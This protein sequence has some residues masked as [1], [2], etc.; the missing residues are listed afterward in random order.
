MVLVLPPLKLR[1]ALQ[2]ISCHWAQ[3]CPNMLSVSLIARCVNYNEERLSAWYVWLL[4]LFFLAMILSCGILFCLQYWLKRRSNFPSRRTLAIFALSDSDS[5]GGYET[6]PY[7]FSG[8]HAHSPNPELCP[9]PALH[10]GS[11]GTGS[12]PSYEDIMT[13]GKH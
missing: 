2:L 11:R 1:T 9:S 6:S 7:A 3:R 13:A 5:L 4:I 10:V 12:L 8:V